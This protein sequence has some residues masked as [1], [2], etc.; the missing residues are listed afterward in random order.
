MGPAEV[1]AE[2]DLP[3]ALRG[4]TEDTL[5]HDKMVGKVCKVPVHAG[6][7]WKVRK[8]PADDDF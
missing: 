5:P 1:G 8:S 6:V 7:L 2:L 3:L 4:V